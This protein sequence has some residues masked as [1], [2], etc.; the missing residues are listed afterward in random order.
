MGTAK[1]MI[2]SLKSSGNHSITILDKDRKSIGDVF[3]KYQIE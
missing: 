3:F 1:L 2:A